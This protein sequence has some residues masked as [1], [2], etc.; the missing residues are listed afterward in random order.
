MMLLSSTKAFQVASRRTRTGTAFSSLVTQTR[1]WDRPTNQQ[2]QESSSS[3]PL[4]NQD[5]VERRNAVNRAKRTARQRSVQE[6][7]DKHLHIKRLLHSNATT[8]NYDNDGAVEDYPVPPLYAVK[9]WVDE[10]LRDELRLSG[11]E[12]RGRVFLET[13]SSGVTTFK[14]LRSELYGFFT[15]LKKDTFLLTASLPTVGEDGTLETRTTTAV[16]SKSESDYSWPIACDADVLKTFQ[17][18]NDLFA[19]VSLLKRPSIQINVWKDP[20]APL[21]PAPPAYLEHM[22]DPSQTE[23][24]TMLS[25]YAFPPNGIADPESFAFT[26]KKLWKVFHA[27]GRVYVAQEGVNAQ[28]SVPTNV[29][30]NFM[31]CCRSVPELGPYM[32]N[33]INVDPKPILLNDFATAGVPIN[34]QPAPPFRN[35]HVRVR[36]QVVADGLDLDTPLDWQSAGYDMPPLEWHAKLEEA[37]REQKESNKPI[38]L[39]CRNTYETDVGIFEGAEPLGTESFRDSW[40]VLKER[41][42]DTPKDAPIMTYCTGG[43]FLQRIGCGIM[44]LQYS[45]RSCVPYPFVFCRRRNSL[46]QSRGLFDARIGLY[47]CLSFGGRH[48]RLRSYP[49]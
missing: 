34:N 49:Q 17:K 37:A 26:L 33:D 15:A 2:Y 28:M 19:S 3:S 31:E 27:L 32:E 14:G 46:C 29:L 38:V 13:N 18:A 16:E 44:R 6:R 20:N 23:S 1:L 25:F 41:L 47:Q 12:K 42:V 10:I 21:P 4:T 43:R 48:Y 9:V 8:N 40:D 30:A 45:P 24:M 35:L 5:L 39:D 11:R 22:P 7:V 36:T